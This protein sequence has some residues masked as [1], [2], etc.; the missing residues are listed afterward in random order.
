MQ[1]SESEQRHLRAAEGW[2]ELGLTSDA[3][4][5]LESIPADKREHPDFLTV[6]WEICRQ[7]KQWELCVQSGE[8]LVK[9][10]PDD[11]QGWIHRSFA[12]HEL[13]RT[14]E[15]YDLL[16][17]VL[18]KFSADTT[19]PYNLAC[20]SA[21]LGEHTRAFEFLDTAFTRAGKRANE[22]K[23]Q[24]LDDPDLEPIWTEIAAD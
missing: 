16:L 15:A 23:L 8:A 3:A 1:L 18:E 13:K 7:L 2:L 22:M 24:A 11:A 14:Q 17:P 9:L 5:E 21:Q 4:E 10:Q 20:Y 6:R 12:L 19:I